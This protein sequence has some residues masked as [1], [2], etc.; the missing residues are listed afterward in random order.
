M[1]SVYFQAPLIFR[2]SAASFSFSLSWLSSIF[3]SSSPVLGRS[4]SA[5]IRL[6]KSYKISSDKYR[7]LHTAD[8]ETFNYHLPDCGHR[9]RIKRIKF[10]EIHRNGNASWSDLK[11]IN[12]SETQPFCQWYILHAALIK[13]SFHLNSPVLG[14]TLKG[15][16]SKW[17]TPL[18]TFTSSRG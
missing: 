7:T 12:L 1:F 14:C 17:F 16:F 10:F 4:N 13:I 2:L 18:L 9:K 6:E 8:N 15:L 11:E 3:S 5:Q